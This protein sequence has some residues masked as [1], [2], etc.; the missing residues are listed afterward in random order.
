MC[1]TAC[2]DTG[3]NSSVYSTCCVCGLMTARHRVWQRVVCAIL[4]LA[5]YVE[6]CWNTVFNSGMCMCELLYIVICM[7]NNIFSNIWC[8]NCFVSLSICDTLT[9]CARCMC[10]CVQSHTHETLC[11]STHGT[12]PSLFSD[13]CWYMVF[14]NVSACFTHTGTNSVSLTPVTKC[15][16]TTDNT[17][18]VPQTHIHVDTTFHTGFTKIIITH[19][20]HTT[21]TM[22]NTHMA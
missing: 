14:N 10:H 9:F 3:V 5:I 17:S 11:L 21:N 20:Q 15:I 1:V 16:V 19:I 4:C 8:T 22:T 18:A 2:G 13:T 7:G 6:I 12:S